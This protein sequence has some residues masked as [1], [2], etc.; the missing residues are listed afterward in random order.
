M[1]ESASMAG[2]QAAVRAGLGV[3]AFVTANLDPDMTLTAHT[4]PQLPDVDIGLVRLPGT[5]GD[6][7][8][9][10]VD[11]LLRGLF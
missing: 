4:L 8:I 2:V 5:D 11:T 9:D 10:A 3:T 6:P 7:F 1:F